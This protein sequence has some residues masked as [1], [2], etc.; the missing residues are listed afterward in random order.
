M[1]Y[2]D[3]HRATRPSSKVVEIMAKMPWQSPSSPYFIE[4]GTSARFLYFT[5]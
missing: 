2:L 3:N 1:I 5:G 4:Q